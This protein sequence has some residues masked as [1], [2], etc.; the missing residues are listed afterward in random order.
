MKKT[1]TI[2]LLTL[3][4]PTLCLSQNDSLKVRK[5]IVNKWKIE[6]IKFD[7]LAPLNSE[8]K[9]SEGKK[10]E[11]TND[12]KIIY[13]DSLSLGENWELDWKHMRILVYVFM[14]NPQYYLIQKLKRKKMV[15]YLSNRNTGGFQVTYK[16]R[17]GAAKK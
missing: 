10:V 15:L 8:I 16:A 12:G 14:D 2:V 4:L 9:K 13:E 11:F 5:L 1:I 17:S 6:K 3:I 7:S